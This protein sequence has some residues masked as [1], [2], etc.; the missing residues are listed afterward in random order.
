[1]KWQEN[2]KG[3]KI[4]FKRN[5]KNKKG[6]PLAWA[7]DITVEQ[8]YGFKYCLSTN[9]HTLAGTSAVSFRVMNSVPTQ[10]PH[11]DFLLKHIP[12]RKQIWYCCNICSHGTSPCLR[13][14]WIS[15]GKPWVGLGSHLSLTTSSS[16]RLLAVPSDVSKV[17]P[18]LRWLHLHPSR[19]FFFSQG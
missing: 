4:W 9:D 3:F 8:L 2:W 17:L 1:M 7:W 19:H 16:R 15:R 10:H 11:S 18:F 14:W 12:C 6:P 5:P 13:W